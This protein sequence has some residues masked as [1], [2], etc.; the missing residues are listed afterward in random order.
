MLSVWLLLAA[1]CTHAAAKNCTLSEFY[2][3]E[4]AGFISGATIQSSKG[5]NTIDECRL[6][7]LDDK[8]CK[9]FHYN[10][11]H[12]EC[13][14]KST[15]KPQEIARTDEK[16]HKNYVYAA[17]MEGPCTAVQSATKRT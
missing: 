13:T 16:W 15:A 6:A 11:K 14:L 9:S 3:P 17:K 4:A 1:V 7:C 8:T 5:V 2:G 10:S 12:S